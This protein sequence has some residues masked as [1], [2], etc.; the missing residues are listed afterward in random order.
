MNARTTLI[1]VILCFAF[2]ASIVSGQSTT[3]ASSPHLER[4]EYFQ[5][6][7]G[8]VFHLIICAADKKSADDGAEAAWQRVDQLNKT[9]SDYDPDSELNRLCRLTDNGPMTESVPVGDDLWDILLRSVDAARLKM[10]ANTIL[11]RGVS[12]GA[13]PSERYVIAQ[14]NM[15]RLTVDVGHNPDLDALLD[16]TTVAAARDA[17]ARVHQ[18]NAILLR[19]VTSGFSD[20]E[21]PER[22]TQLVAACDKLQA[23]IGSHQTLAP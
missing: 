19:G 14:A 1:P 6:R 8:T 22:L 10:E 2:V 17:A 13:V 11:Q 18:Y 21:L 15:L 16:K 23:E 9:L 12:G 7:M 4:F 20:L 5:P 3:V